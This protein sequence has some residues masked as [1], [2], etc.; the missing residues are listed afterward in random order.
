MAKLG[1]SFTMNQIPDIRKVSPNVSPNRNLNRPD[2]ASPFFGLQYGRTLYKLDYL[3]K[4][5]IH[6]LTGARK[7]VY[8][9]LH[10]VCDDERKTCKY[11]ILDREIEARGDCFFHSALYNLGKKYLGPRGTRVEDNIENARKFRKFL[12]DYYIEQTGN[13]SAL[14]FRRQYSNADNQMAQAYAHKF[15]RNVCIFIIRDEAA[16]DGGLSRYD[17]SVELII[18]KNALDQKIDFLILTQA[19]E[20]YTTLKRIPGYRQFALMNKLLDY[21][22]DV[23]PSPINGW[24]SQITLREDIRLQ[25]DRTEAPGRFEDIIRPY[26]ITGVLNVYTLFDT[27]FPE[28]PDL[29]DLA[30]LPDVGDRSPSLSPTTLAGLSEEE[31]I[32][33]LLKKTAKRPNAKSSRANSPSPKASKFGSYLDNAENLSP[34]MLE[35]IRQAGIDPGIKTSNSGSPFLSKNEYNKLPTHDERVQYIMRRSKKNLDTPVFRVNAPNDPSLLEPLL[36]QSAF[37]THSGFGHIGPNYEYGSPINYKAMMGKSGNDFN[38][39]APSLNIPEARKANAPKSPKRGPKPAPKPIPRARRFKANEI[40]A[41]HLGERYEQEARNES[42]ARKLQNGLN[43]TQQNRGSGN[44]LNRKSSVKSSNSPKRSGP[45]R[46]PAPKPKA[47]TVKKV[48]E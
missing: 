9:G 37:A 40:L 28:F 43:R 35:N 16:F 25:H 17:L 34:D 41:K 5:K 27:E 3:L 14:E 45:S 19:P 6:I 12:V 24:K 8:K 32:K 1:N 31:Q 38:P 26:I 11:K 22:I 47:R 13:R 48:D 39:N 29:A 18:N 33:Y 23:I 21:V 2:R 42:L 20:H 15:N 4:K 30:D 46:R 36:P 44:G 10:L 7:R